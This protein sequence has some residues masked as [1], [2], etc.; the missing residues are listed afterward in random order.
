M[1]GEFFQRK[2]GKKNY[3]SLLFILVTLS[4]VRVACQ[5]TKNGLFLKSLLNRLA[6]FRGRGAGTRLPPIGAIPVNGFF[7]F[8]RGF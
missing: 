6:S 4:F 8:F 1:S 3:Y 2:E 7:V 5:K